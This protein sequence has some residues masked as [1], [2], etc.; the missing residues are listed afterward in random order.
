MGRIDVYKSFGGFDVEFKRCEDTDFIIR[1]AIAGAH[2][3]GVKEALVD[4]YMTM[5]SKK[6]IEIEYL[7]NSK[8]LDK[9]KNIFKKQSH[10]NFA[11]SWILIRHLILNNKIKKATL[12]SLQCFYLY[13]FLFI[14]RLYLMYPNRKI[15]IEFSNFHKN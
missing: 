7:Y 14:R 1:L 13:P 4:Q 11:K 10:Y 2:F 6:S 9:H 12:K 8:L 15:N 3:L 5:N